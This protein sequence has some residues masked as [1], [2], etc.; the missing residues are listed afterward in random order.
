MF[1]IGYLGGFMSAQLIQTD[2]FISDLRELEKHQKDAR[3]KKNNRKLR[4]A[5]HLLGDLGKQLKEKTP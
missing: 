4:A 5:F 2:M 1:L 3:D